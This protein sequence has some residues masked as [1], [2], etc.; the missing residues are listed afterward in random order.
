MNKTPP[1]G[2]TIE[3]SSDGSDVV[4]QWR[5]AGR[6]PVQYIPMFFGGMMLLMSVFLPFA[7]SEANVPGAEITLR[8]TLIMAVLQV[9]IGAFLLY[10]GLRVRGRESIRLNA[11]RI[12]YDTGPSVLPLPLML[13]FGP[14]LQYGPQIMGR[15]SMVPTHIFR[16]K[17]TQATEQAGR[18]VLERVGERQRLRF[19]IGADRIEIG[20]LLREP[21]R[22]WLAAQLNEWLAS[23]K[24]K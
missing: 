18:F 8:E 19:D 14:T 16:K 2:S 6:H 9:C 7:I 10:A 23:K 12:E 15:E 1:V 4:Y 13:I 3:F 17:Y 22:E 5:P 20:N 21:E 11:T 24:A